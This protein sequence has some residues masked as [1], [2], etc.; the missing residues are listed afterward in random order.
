MNKNIF[1]FVITTILFLFIFYLTLTLSQASFA[2]E[3][4]LNVSVSKPVEPK[5]D[6]LARV[7]VSIVAIIICVII[8]FITRKRK[9]VQINTLDKKIKG[10]ANIVRSISNE[11][12]TKNL[13][14]QFVK[15]KIYFNDLISTASIAYVNYDSNII[16]SI[17]SEIEHTLDSLNLILEDSK[18]Q[19]DDKKTKIINLIN[20][21]STKSQDLLDDYKS[22]K[23]DHLNKI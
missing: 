22:I 14:T 11:N 21:C 10:L 18:M 20:N 19:N 16:L 9:N 12:R 8:L 6:K 23:T 4:I 17:Q 13:N 7:L 5:S 15:T 3:F 1:R 2:N